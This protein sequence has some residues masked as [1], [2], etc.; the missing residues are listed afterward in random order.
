MMKR[1]IGLALMLMMIT[2]LANAQKPTRYNLK[3]GDVFTLTANIKQDI[4]QEVQ[5]QS[6][7]TDQSI[8][9]TDELE[10]TSVDG[11]VYTIKITGKRRAIALESVM[12]SQ[13]M[14]SDKDDAASMPLKILNGK[15]YIIEMNSLGRVLKISGVSEMRDVMKKE[16]SD[17]GMGAV[18]DQ[19]LASFNEDVM[20]NSFESQMSIYDENNGSEWTV[21]TTSVVNNIPVELVNS[22]R[23]DDDKTILAEATIDMSGTM[24]M[25][26]TSVKSVMTGDQQT[27]ID[28]DS[29]TGMPTKIQS[30]QT[31]DGNLEAQG[32]TIPM[33]IVS[34]TTTT[35]VKK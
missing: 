7:T 31:V 11:D 1:I 12:G 8:V 30:I 17:A 35:I 6:I 15:F 13:E 16:F 10:V 18:A 29:K 25:M 21:T 5:G 24:E 22:L 2:S 27:I 32:M 19:M 26:G 20:K 23:W 33:S 14:D 9:N 34:E 4:E 28:L 3:K